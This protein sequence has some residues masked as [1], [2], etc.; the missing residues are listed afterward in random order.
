[1]ADPG[2]HSEQTTPNGKV[3][4]PDELDLSEPTIVP[5]ALKLWEQIKEQITNERTKNKFAVFINFEDT[6]IDY[7]G[8]GVD[9]SFDPGY[10]W[11]PQNSAVSEN[12]K[13]LA[14]SS[15]TALLTGAT[16]QKAHSMVRIPEIFYIGCHGFDL[17]PVDLPTPYVYG[18]D[19]EDQGLE[20][21]KYSWAEVGGGGEETGGALGEAMGRLHMLLEGV[22]KV[23]IEGK[24]F[25]V[26]VSHQ[27]ISEGVVKNA[28]EQV[29]S[30][31]PMLRLDEAHREYI[32]KEELAW[33]KG[34]AVA[35]LLESQF[36]P[37]LKACDDTGDI[38][39]ISEEFLIS[40][41]Y[42]GNFHA[43]L[44]QGNAQTRPNPNPNPLSR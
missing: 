37:A 29:L 19:E 24:P 44:Y 33:H 8:E 25:E 3:G 28:V 1:L 14:K 42:R 6:L 34:K 40:R 12:L 36:C 10:G 15:P 13:M 21:P 23:E 38:A 4:T 2:S 20:H 9:S 32:L 26:T 31:M 11:A 17:P 27:G 5:G 16:R 43:H 30:A 7:A 39:G 41:K 22:E 18:P 35:W